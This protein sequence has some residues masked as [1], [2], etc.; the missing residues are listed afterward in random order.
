MGGEKIDVKGDVAVFQKEAVGFPGLHGQPGR[1]IRGH[2]AG[3]GFP[4][5]RPGANEGVA[6]YAV[7]AGANVGEQNRKAPE[8]IDLR[9]GRGVVRGDSQGDSKSSE[10]GRWENVGV[11]DGAVKLVV[12][13]IAAQARPRRPLKPTE[14]PSPEHG[15]G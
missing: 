13:D 4:G 5:V 15:R 1:Q 10:N 2:K 6:G 12:A 14:D 9:A 7:H 8:P 3:G 11:Q